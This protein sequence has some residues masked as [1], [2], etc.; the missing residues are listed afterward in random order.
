[1]QSFL[2]VKF[3]VCPNLFSQLL[4]SSECEAMI[5]IGFEAV[6]EGF[7]VGIVGHLSRTVHALNITEGLESVT[8][9]V[10]R[11]FDASVRVKDHGAL[12][13]S[14]GDGPIQCQQGELYALALAQTPAEYLPGV[15][16][17]DRCHV[18]PLVAYLEVG[19][20]T[21]PDLI[22]SIDPDAQGA[23]GDAL[24]EGMAGRMGPIQL[25]GPGFQAV[26]A[27]QAGDPFLGN[28]PAPVLQGCMHPWTA[29]GVSA[30]FMNFLYFLQQALLFLLPRAGLS[31][32]PGIVTGA[33]D[34][35]DPAQDG[36]W[37]LLPVLF[38]EREDFSFRSEQNRMAFFRISCSSLSRA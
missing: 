6:K 34:A 32:S 24:K 30:L 3:D 38:Y 5:G 2:V 19:D 1:M 13:S 37:V 21:H 4:F 25:G 36:D 17:H 22:R 23:V 8:N 10:G 20:V 7:H 16:V 11:V 33:G 26:L 27:H 15:S 35:I 14:P 29:V 18:A 12:G 28:L 9:G 31:V